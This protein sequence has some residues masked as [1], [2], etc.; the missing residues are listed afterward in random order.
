MGAAMAALALALLGDRKLTPAVKVITEGY[1]KSGM[2][3]EVRR[4][5]T[6]HDRYLINDGREV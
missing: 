5:T 4:T 1:A 3:L 2:P 6:F